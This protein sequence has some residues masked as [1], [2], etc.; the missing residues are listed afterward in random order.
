MN[1]SPL[2][3]NQ[4]PWT[5]P[6]TEFWARVTGGVAKAISVFPFILFAFSVMA[7]W[8]WLTLST[9]P[10]ILLGLLG[11]ALSAWIAHFL[12]LIL[13]SIYGLGCEKLF[14]RWG[15]SSRQLWVGAMVGGAVGLTLVFPFVLPF[16]A[17]GAL[18]IHKAVLGTLG[19]VLPITVLA[20]AGAILGARRHPEIYSTSSGYWTRSLPSFSIA[21]LG[22]LTLGISV[23]LALLKL[24]MLDNLIAFLMVWLA[25]QGITMIGLLMLER[26]YTRLFE[27]RGTSLTNPTD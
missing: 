8:N 24:M 6:A 2:V 16:M 9:I 18:E 5:D 20:Q 23:V 10:N 27:D 17:I 22:S 1:E 21:M 12:A 3:G 13:T 4:A 7:E 11:T 19:F 14:C 26:L 15:V 25:A